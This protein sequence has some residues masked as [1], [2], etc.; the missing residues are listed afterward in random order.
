[1]I[2]DL[3]KFAAPKDR[4]DQRQKDMELWNQWRDNGKRPEDMRPLLNEFRGMIRS[5]ANKWA[6]R[7]EVPPA[8]IHQEFNKQFH[9]ALETY[10]PNKGAA[11]G[12]WVNTNLQKGQRWV[13]QHQ[14]IARIG[15]QRSYKIGQFNTALSQLDDNLGREPT[16]DELS[17]HLGW[18]PKEV[19]MLR[20]EIR[21]SN[22]ASAWE[23]DPVEILPSREKEA[24]KFVDFDLTAEEK[25]VKE[26]TLGEGGKPQLRPMEIAKQLNLSGP[27]VSRLRKSIADKLGKHLY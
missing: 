6:G 22:I 18:A 5:Q 4:A 16:T 20:T 3:D 19:G 14:N 8:A 12:T 10:D 27:K 9:R 2:L 13:R 11:L 23:A 15:E 21:K 1:M 25:L 24:L 7:V 26:Y 17:E